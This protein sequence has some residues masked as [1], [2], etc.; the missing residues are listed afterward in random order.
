MSCSYWS[1]PA[2]TAPTAPT[3]P[4]LPLLL[5]LYLPLLIPSLP[6]LSPPEPPYNACPAPP[7]APWPNCPG[8]AA[9]AGQGWFKLDTRHNKY[10]SHLLGMG[11]VGLVASYY[12]SNV[13]HPVT[14]TIVIVCTPAFDGTPASGG[15]WEAGSRLPNRV[16]HQL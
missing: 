11:R 2:P 7:P 3:A 13:A 1:P 4:H 8:Q 6:L 15:S 5:L 16:G 9:T 10:S 14:F 12:A